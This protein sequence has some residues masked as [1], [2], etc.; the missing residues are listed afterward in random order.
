MLLHGFPTGLN[1]I[2]KTLY[3]FHVYIF[4]VAKKKRENISDILRNIVILFSSFYSYSV[5]EQ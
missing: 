4:E 1:W 5:I 3:V 2:I